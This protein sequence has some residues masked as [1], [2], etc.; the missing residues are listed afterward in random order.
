[1]NKCSKIDFVITWVDGSDPAWISE[2]NKHVSTSQAIDIND[3]RYRSWDNLHYWFRSIEKFAPWVNKIHFVTWGHLPK[4]L[5]FNHPKLNIVKH[6][7][8][9]DNST[10]PLFNSHPIENSLHKIS[11][12]SEQF[13]YFNDDM[14]LLADLKP[15]RFFKYG[16]PRDIAVGNVVSI[17]GIEHILVNNLSI[18]NKHFSK[19][20]QVKENI[21]KW[22]NPRYGLH[23]MKT[24]C[25]LPW[26]QFTG[27]FDPHQPQPFLKTTFEE[28]WAKEPEVLENT[29]KSRFRNMS[30]VSQYLFRYWQLAS[31]NFMPIGIKDTHYVDLKKIS[32]CQSASTT[33]I[34][35]RYHMICIN[36]KLEKNGDFEVAKQIINNAFE[37]KLS[38]KSSYEI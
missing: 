27:F 18:I 11:G 4:W 23:T 5:N 37:K 28:V 15:T 21:F 20:E 8:Y 38:K 17:G 19:K 10:L 16:L 24:I 29:S 26:K 6:K 34:S 1:M 25:L 13:V 30:D 36:D 2:F 7:D 9:L 35:D 31:G 32:D 22:I 12:L 14:F 33:I 3:E